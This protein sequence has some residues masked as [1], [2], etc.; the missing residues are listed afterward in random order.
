[1][2]KQ[3]GEVAF[4]AGGREVYLPVYGSDC[5]IFLEDSSG[6]RYCREEDYELE[7]M[8][9]PDKLAKMAAVY[10]TDDVNLDIWMC[11]RGRVLVVINEENVQ[12]MKRVC[13]YEVLEDN[14]RRD[15]RMNLIRY[16]YEKDKM[17]ELDSFLF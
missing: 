5:R 8:L 11:E 3:K 15:I 1:M 7:R 9:I 17:Q 2:R 14:M 4:K 6:C 16:F 13:G 10:I 12:L